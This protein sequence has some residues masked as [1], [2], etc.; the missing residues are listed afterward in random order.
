M[1]INTVATFLLITLACPSLI[2]A[3]SSA[4]RK[5]QELINALN[6]TAFVQQ[7]RE[8]QTGIE[9][10]VATFKISEADIPERDVKRVQLFYNQS[11]LKF[12]AVLNKLENDLTSR[13]MRKTIAQDPQRY[14]KKLQTDLST[15]IKY[16]N[17]NCKKLMEKLTE[18]D[19]AL[20]L[21]TAKGLLDGILGLVELFKS[22]G[23]DANAITVAYLES[24]FIQPLRLKKWDEIE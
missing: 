8:Y 10:D 21:D 23:E 16:Y 6:E 20:E 4:E 1:K 22:K 17:D 7:Y 24:E 18:T 12:D 2:L 13:P 3:Q 15:A 9:L 11:R 5:A 14:T 19:S